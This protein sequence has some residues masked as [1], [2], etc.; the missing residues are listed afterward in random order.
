MSQ[1]YRL[2]KRFDEKGIKGLKDRR[3]EGNA[4]KVSLDQV[5]LIKSVLTY[6]RE[7]TSEDLRAD[8]Q[9]NWGIQLHKTRIDQ[10]RR[11]FN[12]TRVKGG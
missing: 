9:E 7:F 10:Y 5:E 4:K 2:K 6:N 12:L 8:L 11:E 1:Y 3:T